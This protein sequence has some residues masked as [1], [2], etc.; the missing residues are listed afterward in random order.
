[1][2]L[3]DA[4]SSTGLTDAPMFNR[5]SMTALAAKLRAVHTRSLNE[6]RL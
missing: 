3:I 6:Y 1:M 2:D 4:V 5:S